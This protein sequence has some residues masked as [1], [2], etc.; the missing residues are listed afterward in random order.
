[1]KNDENFAS[2]SEIREMIAE[3]GKTKITDVMVYL[4][5]RMKKPYDVK[6]ARKNARELIK[7]MKKYM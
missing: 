3:S 7:E 1:M 4:E 5:R 2:E 6:L